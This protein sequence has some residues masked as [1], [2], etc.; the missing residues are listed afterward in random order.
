MKRLT[1]ASNFIIFTIVLILF[2]IIQPHKKFSSELAS[3]LTDKDKKFYKLSEK[4]N[5]SKTLLISVEGFKRED[6]LKL[7]KIKLELSLLSQIVMHNQLNNKELQKY[8]N[9]YKMYLHTLNYKNG[10]DIDVNNILFNMYNNI[11]SS[12]VYFNINQQDPL[13]II[14]SNKI[15]NNIKLKDGQLVLDKYGYLAVFSIENVTD[16]ISRV[17]IYSDIHNILKKYKDIKSFSPIFYYVENSRAIKDD[18]QK[19]KSLK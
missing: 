16:E 5:Y 18:I 11:L 17:K 8:K 13:S 6:M 4:F 3:M 14:K 1:K 12:P 2:I 7:K 9:K 19:I 10:N 15:K